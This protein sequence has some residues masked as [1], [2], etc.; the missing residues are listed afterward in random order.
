[1]RLRIRGPSGTSTAILEENATVNDLIS[2]IKEKTGISKFDI[3]YGYP[4]RPLTLDSKSALLTSLDVKLNGEQ[5]T[6]SSKEDTPSAAPQGYKESAKQPPVSNS[7][8]NHSFSGIES[9]LP[10]QASQEAESSS[11]PIGLQHKAMEGEVPEIPIPE[12]GATLGMR[13]S[14]LWYTIDG[15]T[16]CIV[17]RVM[18]D[19]NSCLFR[20]FG[21]AVLPGDDLSMTELRSLVASTIQEQPDVYSTV[22]LEKK[23]D[24]Y[25]RWIQTEDAWGGGIE[26][27]I[28]SKHFEIEICS[29]DVQVSKESKL[30]YVGIANQG[31]V[32]STHRQ[33]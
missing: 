29:I 19:D 15:L 25:C 24:Q 5:L 6:I 17:L 30:A 10:A 1:M 32:V 4:P 2:Q 28:L 14:S 18:P 13:A 22:V 26:M 3:K 31:N 12:R 21:T 9:S 27:S 16:K 11:K 33:I 20:A 8:L 7:P 23:P